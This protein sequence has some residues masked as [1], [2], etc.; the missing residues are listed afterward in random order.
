MLVDNA[1]VPTITVVSPTTRM[2]GKSPAVEPRSYKST[3]GGEVFS[4]RR[5]SNRI[6]DMV[7]FGDC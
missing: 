2:V 4:A 1:I 7:R 3:P 6:I 5:G